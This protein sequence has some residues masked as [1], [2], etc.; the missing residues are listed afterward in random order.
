[1]S[2]PT[3]QQINCIEQDDTLLYSLEG[4]L[5]PFVINCPPGYDCNTSDSFQIVCCGE[6]MSVFFPIGASAD[7]KA[8]LINGLIEQCGIRQR[9][10]NE[11][12]PD[13]P[14]T[15][16]YYYNATK[17][18]YAT[19]PDGSHFSYTVPAGTFASSTQELADSQAQ[20]YA[21]QKA[22][23]RKMCLSNINS[24]AC[25]NSPYSQSIV[26][27]GGVGS[28]TFQVIDGSLP[29]GINLN[30]SN[31]TISG[32][33]TVGFGYN[34][35]IRV[36]ASDGSYTVK[37]YSICVYDIFPSQSTLSLA[38]INVPVSYQFSTSSCA[39]GTLSW[40]IAGG[41]LP[42]G[43][44]IDE[45]T[46]NLLGAPTVAGTYNFTVKLQDEST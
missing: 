46:G 23:L 12:P 30:E 18:C 42:P 5:Y 27:T 13:P 14:P 37:Y 28:K 35:A 11:I 10:C 34:F 4:S 7:T 19:C 1:M 41:G 6:L 40:Q 31:G 45:Q 36:M 26:V 44:T 21:C 22:A 39:I 29:T 15:K 16:E 32:T 24:K 17:S 2:C 3:C 38:Q 25:A 33:P 43:V 20:S 8:A 9:Y